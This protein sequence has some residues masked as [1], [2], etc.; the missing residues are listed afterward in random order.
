MIHSKH[1]EKVD[2]DKE[3]ME[4]F[5]K[6]EVNIPFLMD[7]KKISKYAKFLKDLSIYKRMLKGN[8]KINLGKN[9]LTH[10]K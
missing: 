7:I 10:I 9:V 6:V 1:K 4:T 8:D 5:T 3:I 2:K